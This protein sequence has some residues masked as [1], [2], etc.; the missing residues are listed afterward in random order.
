MTKKAEKRSGTHGGNGTD[1]GL[2][3]ALAPLVA[4]MTA[5]ASGVTTTRRRNRRK[6]ESISRLC[7]LR[8]G[9]TPEQPDVPP[10]ENGEKRNRCLAFTR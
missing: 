6:T 5:C 7:P 4:G 8:Q 1:P 3:T 2:A 9:L 10:P